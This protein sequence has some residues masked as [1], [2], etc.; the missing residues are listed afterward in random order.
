QPPISTLCPYTTL[1]RSGFAFERWPRHDARGLDELRA[2]ARAQELPRAPSAILAYDADA[3]MVGATRANAGSAGV[4]DDVSADQAP[5][6]SEEH[7]SELQ[8]RGHLV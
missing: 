5:L 3:A 1:F 7:T 6:R 8:S 4:A 2:S